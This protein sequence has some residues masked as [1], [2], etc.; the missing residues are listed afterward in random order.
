MIKRLIGLFNY[1]KGLYHFYFGDLEIQI[2]NWDQDK[3]S[4]L[5]NLI[6]NLNSKFK[7]GKIRIILL[8]KGFNASA[9]GF[10]GNR[11][12]ISKDLIEILNENELEAVIAHE[13]SHLYFRHSILLLT[14]ISIFFMPV[15]LLTILISFFPGNTVLLLLWFLAALAFFFSPKIV[16]WVKLHH[17][18]ISDREAALRIGDPSD[19]ETALIKMYIRYPGWTKRPS[20]LSVIIQGL[21]WL[22]AYFFGFTHPFL[23]ERIEHIK[24]A[25][26]MRNKIS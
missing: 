19:L 24:F 16:N 23:K 26:E 1:I 11:I 10:L 14:L 3:Y 15:F 2:V 9:I 12:R 21:T 4:N 7:I 8:D 17:E 5:Q 13:F 25:N 22:K 20:R 6:K 18:I